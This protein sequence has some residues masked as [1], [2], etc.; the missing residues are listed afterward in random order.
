MRIER[1]NPHRLAMFL[2]YPFLKPELWNEELVMK[3]FTEV[4]GGF[5]A[6]LLQEILYYKAVG[7]PR[8]YRFDIVLLNEMTKCPTCGHTTYEKQYQVFPAAEGKLSGDV[9]K[10]S[11]EDLEW[12][13]AESKRCWETALKYPEYME[14][15]YRK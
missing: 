5:E 6:S 15:F 14:A 4:K 8:I 2:P 13:K 12:A 10:L 7:K 1:H 11:P 9:D 3:H